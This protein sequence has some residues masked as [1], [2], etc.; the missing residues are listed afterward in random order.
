MTERNDPVRT[1]ELEKERRILGFGRDEA[2]IKMSRSW[3][4]ESMGKGYTYN[5]SWL[6]RPIIQYPMD[7]VAV[8]EIIWEVQPD[9]VIETGIAHG[10]SLIL[11]ASML[12]MLD[13]CEAVKAGRVLNP[14]ATCRRVLGIDVDIRAHNLAAIK[15]HPMYHRIDMIQGSSISAEIMAMAT[16]KAK[17][18]EKVLVCLDSNHT[19]DHVLAELEAYSP[20]TSVGSYC[21]V[22]DTFIEDAPEDMF[23]DREWSRGNNPKTAVRDYLRKLQEEGR[24]GLDGKPLHFEI[25]RNIERKLMITGAPGGYLKRIDSGQSRCCEHED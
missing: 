15:A 14:L 4:N 24:Q 12:A 13:Y 25:D 8:Q 23:S 11:S 1:F 22:F 19:H 20:L 3:L 16:E 7:M 17:G 2:F 18:Y 9:L 6:S 10:G 21:V 5:F